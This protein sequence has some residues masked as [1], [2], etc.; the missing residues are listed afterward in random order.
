MVYRYSLQQYQPGIF[1]QRPRRRRPSHENI[2]ILGRFLGIT[3][4]AIMHIIIISFVLLRQRK[5]HERSDQ[6]RNRYDRVKF[7]S[8]E[9]S[10]LIDIQGSESSAK[11]MRLLE[12]SRL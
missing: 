4:S 11:P 5:F 8:L 6:N 7:T 1:S 12:L 2:D 10:I 9:L 3:I